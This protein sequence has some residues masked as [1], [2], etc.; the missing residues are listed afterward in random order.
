MS[1]KHEVE[2][3]AV[4]ITRLF[5]EDQTILA[6]FSKARGD[7]AFEAIYLSFRDEVTK[8]NPNFYDA[9]LCDLWAQSPDCPDLVRRDVEFRKSLN[10]RI[11]S[12][13]SEHGWPQRA[14]VGDTAAAQFIFLFGHADNENEW[15]LMQLE[16]IGRVYR[17]DHFHP[18]LYAH[19]HDRLANV[20]GTPQIYGSVMG[21]GKTKGSAKLYWPLRDDEVATDGRRAQVGLALMEDD[22]EKF[23]QGATIGPYMTPLL[24]GNDWTIENVYR[25]DVY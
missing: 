15:R 16:T 14:T 17:E 2:T 23:R 10:A 4:E 24:E 25:C 1:S 13:I 20:A 3:L 9:M 6:A 22:L 18:R 8:H 7:P 12:I 5:N 19:L 21:P 11:K